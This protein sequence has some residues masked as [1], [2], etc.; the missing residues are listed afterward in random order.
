M[1]LWFFVWVFSLL[2]KKKK[3]FYLCVH[4]MLLFFVCHFCV[5]VYEDFFGGWV[6]VFFNGRRVCGSLQLYQRQECNKNV[7]ACG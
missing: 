6:G 1:V 5:Y 4:F 7:V 3:I 2:F